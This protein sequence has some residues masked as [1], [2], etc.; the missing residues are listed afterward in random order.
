MAKIK[1][2]E[3]PQTDKKG[4]DKYEKESFHR[5]L[6]EAEMIK[7]DP[8]KLSAAMEIMKEHEKAMKSM[9]MEQLKAHAADL[10]HD[11]VGMTAVPDSDTKLEG[12]A[13]EKKKGDKKE[14]KMHG[15]KIS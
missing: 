6:M 11:P 3:D 9:N 2:A 1:L 7:N 5:T 14:D 4:F 15:E 12:K 8:K 13:H 10:E